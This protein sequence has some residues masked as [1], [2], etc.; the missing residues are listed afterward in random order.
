MSS[1]CLCISPVVN[2][3]CGRTVT[4]GLWLSSGNKLLLLQKKAPRCGGVVVAVLPEGSKEKSRSA[5]DDEPFEF[6][7]GGKIAYLDEQDI[8]SILEPPKELIPL[9]SATYNPAAYV[10]AANSFSPLY[11]TVKEVNE[12]MPTEQPCDLAYELGNGL[13]DPT[14]LPEGFPSPVRH[15]QPFNDQLVVY[16]RNV[17][18]GVVVGQAWREGRELEQVPKKFCREILMV[19][20]Y[21]PSHKGP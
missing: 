16:V 10:C 7:P 17:G 18:P 20:D 4:S 15:R 12:V 9:D 5:W 3:R 21:G 14:N 8:V 1:S 19:K 11:F 13:L 2:P 6:L